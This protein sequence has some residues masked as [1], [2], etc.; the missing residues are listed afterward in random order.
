MAFI[1]LF[2]FNYFYYFYLFFLT[3]CVSVVDCCGSAQFTGFESLRN[4]ASAVVLNMLKQ[5]ESKGGKEGKRK[6]GKEIGG[7]GGRRN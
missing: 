1:L 2:F 3:F 6:G 7:K 5:G 4:E